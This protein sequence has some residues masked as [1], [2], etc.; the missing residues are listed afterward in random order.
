MRNVHDIHLQLYAP[1]SR[2]KNHG[3][4]KRVNSE[5]NERKN[6]HKSLR[7]QKPNIHQS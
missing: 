3:K 7:F 4:M 2:Y 5:V 1:F 6:E